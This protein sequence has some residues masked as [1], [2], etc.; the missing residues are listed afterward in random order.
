MAALA[1]FLTWRIDVTQQMIIAQVW[2]RPIKI[3]NEVR[4]QH[5]K[6]LDEAVTLG[7]KAD[8]IS[9]RRTASAGGSTVPSM[10]KTFMSKF[11]L[12]PLDRPS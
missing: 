4:L 9:G 12:P 6:G 1:M 11:V 10:L 8:G 7:D 2:K 3:R 5:G